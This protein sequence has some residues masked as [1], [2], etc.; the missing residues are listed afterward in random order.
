MV[1]TAPNWSEQPFSMFA[2]TSFLWV[3]L[4]RLTIIYFPYLGVF[5]IACYRSHSKRKEYSQ[6]VLGSFRKRGGR[7]RFLCQPMHHGIMSRWACCYWIF[8]QN[9]GQFRHLL[10][11]KSPGRSGEIVARFYGNRLTLKSLIPI[12]FGSNPRPIVIQ[13]GVW[14]GLCSNVAF[15]SSE[16]FWLLISTFPPETFS[17][18][19]LWV[20]SVLSTKGSFIAFL[21]FSGMN[22]LELSLSLGILDLC[23]LIFDLS[24]LYCLYTQF[25]CYCSDCLTTD[26]NID[27][28]Q[29]FQKFHLNSDHESLNVITVQRVYN[30]FT[31]I[32]YWM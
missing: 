8:S 24:L 5:F 27:T 25:D 20:L 7:C 11:I 26:N 14:T 16:A 6:G 23:R 22:F 4:F 29:K 21:C 1:L 30:L 13:S 3:E 12:S 17:P 18:F 31:T 15:L 10:S 9:A 32:D 2:D 28:T 19:L